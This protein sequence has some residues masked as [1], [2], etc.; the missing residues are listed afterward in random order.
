[1]Y[2]DEDD[3]EPKGDVVN[4]AF[5]MRVEI[6]SYNYDQAYINDLWLKA[7]EANITSINKNDTL[8]LVDLPQGN[9]CVGCVGMYNALL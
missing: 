6:K 3:H 8:D 7:M 2:G 1:M 5:L 4:Y 9:K